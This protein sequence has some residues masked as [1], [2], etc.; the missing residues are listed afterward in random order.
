MSRACGCKERADRSGRSVRP[1]RSE[2]GR[3]GV[4]EY[5][6]SIC[7]FHEVIPALVVDLRIP[8]AVVKAFEFLEKLR[9]RHRQSGNKVLGSRQP[10]PSRAAHRNVL[11]LLAELGDAPNYLGVGTPA[12]DATKSLELEEVKRTTPLRLAD[13]TEVLVQDRLVNTPRGRLVS[14]IGQ[15]RLITGQL[16]DPTRAN[17]PRPIIRAP[18]SRGSVATARRTRGSRKSKR[19]AIRRSPRSCAPCSSPKTGVGLDHALIHRGHLHGDIL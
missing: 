1:W 10:V 7:T 6:R 2:K 14:Q 12:S 15:V 5:Q 13:D 4:T 8:A 11:L 3:E 19:T 9:Q 16:Q 17:F 18:C